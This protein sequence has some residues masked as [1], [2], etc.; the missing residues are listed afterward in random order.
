MIRPN[1]RKA[2]ILGLSIAAFTTNI[3]FAQERI[4][5]E[6]NQ[7]GEIAAVAPTILMIDEG[8]LTDPVK[9]TD[10]NEADRGAAALGNEGSVA[11]EPEDAD[12]TFELY[13]EKDASADE[14]LMYTT[15]IADGAVD[16][17]VIDPDQAV[18][19]D[20]ELKIQITSTG[21]DDIRTIAAESSPISDTDSKKAAIDTSVLVLAIA[22]GAALIGGSV[23]VA[24]RKKDR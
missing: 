11:V 21:A 14:E 3:A 10:A 19:S 17:G 8:D 2:A 15:G 6:A 13:L 24:K 22:G 23:L 5:P 12:M 7:R 20:D 9:A 4:A 1:I 18:S 16:D